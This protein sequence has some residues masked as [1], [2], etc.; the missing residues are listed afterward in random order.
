MTLALYG[1]SRQRQF[2]LLLLAIVTVLAGVAAAIALNQGTGSAG[3]PHAATI[4]T[5]SV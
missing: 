2:A 3:K 1:K 5:C 4:P